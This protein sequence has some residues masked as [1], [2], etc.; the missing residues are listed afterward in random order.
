MTVLKTNLTSKKDMVNA[1]N[2]GA[3]L[4]D[5]VG[6]KMKM[7]GYVVYEQ[8]N[9][10]GKVDK[11]V[12]IKTEDGFVGSTS[13]NVIDTVLACSDA[14]DDTEFTEGIDFTVRS[15]TSKNGRTFLTLELL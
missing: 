9:A 11:V 10:D 14:F 8:E 6:V 4:K 12:A 15:D 1:T 5:L 7:H 13:S 3:S 2:S